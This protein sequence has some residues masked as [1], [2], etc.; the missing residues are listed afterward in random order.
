MLYMTIIQVTNHDK[1]MIY[2][3]VTQSHDT[4]KNIEDSGI[5]LEV[6]HTYW[7]ICNSSTKD[8]MKEELSKLSSKKGAEAI[9]SR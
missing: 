4:K 6:N 3:T 7:I 9:L 5:V 1:S 2:V 8:K